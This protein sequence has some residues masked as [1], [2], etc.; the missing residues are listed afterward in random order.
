MRKRSRIRNLSLCLGGFA[1]AGAARHANAQF[2]VS[3]TLTPANYGSALATQTVNTGFG[4][5]TVGDGTSAGGSELDAGYG[6]VQSGELYL[7]FAGNFEN[8]G[9]HLNIFLDDGRAGGQSVLNASASGFLHNMNGSIFSPSFSATYAIDANVSGTTLYIDQ[10]DLVK[11]TGNYLG[12]VALTGGIG[13]NQNLT[14]VKVAL[15][16][17][18]AAGVVG[19]GGTGSAANPTAADAVTTGLELGIPL[20]ALGN[21]AAGSSIEVM[22][23]VN[24]GG[25]GENYLS[26]QFLPGLP[27]G[28]TD[29]GGGGPYTG[30]SPGLF[31]LLGVSPGY[32]SVNI[33]ALVPNGTWIA[34]GSGSWGTAAD[35]SN[36]YVP[37]LAGDSATFASATANSTVSLASNYS[38]GSMSFSSSYSYTIAS[39]GGKLTLDD[40]AGTA[41]VTDVAGA[42]TISAPVVLNSNTNV[43]IIN[44]G[45]TMTISGNISGAGSLTINDP[46]GGGAFALAEV[47]L[48]GN[49]S[50]SGGTIVNSG[51]LQLGSST[52]LPTGTA[53]TLSA[54]DVPAGVVDLNGFNATVSSITVL[55]GPNTQNLGAYGQ[56]INTSTLAATATLTYAGTIPNPSNFTGNISDS[57]G[58]GGSTTALVVSSGSLT[59]SGTN[60]YGGGTTVDTGATLILS[61]TVGKSLPTGGNVANNGSLVVN[62]TISAGNVSGSGTTTVNSAMS[63]FAVGF[64]QAGGLVNNGAVT[65]SGSGTV[66]PISGTGTLTLGGTLQLATNSGV[67][68]Q[69]GLVINTGGALDI[70]NNHIFIDYGANPDPVAAIRAYLINGRNGGTWN[71]TGG[72]DSSVAALPANSAYGVGY[73]DSA[74]PG[75]PAGLA[76]DQIEIKYTLLGDATLTGTVTGTDFTILATNLG[77]T[78][79]GWDQGDFLYTGTVTGSDFTA[80]VT[81]LGKTASGADVAL[82]AADWAAVDAFAAANGLMADVPEPV[83]GSMMLIAGTGMLMRRRRKQLA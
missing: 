83:T 19:D 59:L 61:S 64:S 73:A 16:N 47:I 53:L 35:W 33:P 66:G 2:A 39:A 70:A 11:N 44:H 57:S 50:Y 6:V 12:G 80:L 27:V 78:V 38:V 51:N 62:D 20:T 60:T 45:D 24:G 68:T 3:G 56:I 75:N 74:D 40:G 49:N 67:S 63:L 71:G 9:N 23:D 54:V 26:N 17:T 79:S 29:L 1:L 32:F 52:A 8:N 41:T 4:D 18:N 7:F 69:G 72:I 42:H 76:T 15:N 46:G 58:S 30:S 55:T 43:S 21:P 28:T 5:S 81:N 31:N 10:Y 25:G 13:N 37:H 34:T 65:V 36:G 82:P 14:G 48:S 77:K 22:A